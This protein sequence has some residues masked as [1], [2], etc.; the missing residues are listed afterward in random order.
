MPQR[1]SMFFRQ[2]DKELKEK[3]TKPDIP[4]AWGVQIVI[5]S[6]LV[7]GIMHSSFV[8]FYTAYIY[9]SLAVQLV[10]MIIFFIIDKKY[11]NLPY[12]GLSILMA[13]ILFY[14]L[15]LVSHYVLLDTKRICF[16]T[17]IESKSFRKKESIGKIWIKNSA[18]VYENVENIDEINGIGKD[19]FNLLPKIGSKIQICGD[20]SKVGFSYSYI[21]AGEQDNALKNQIHE[22]N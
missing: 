12:L 1:I 19:E 4:F 3:S 6:L 21:E 7:L 16:E 20:I 13:I 11:I 18:L 5:I 22:E 17:T 9:Y 2:I 14:G 15:P 10:L 8:F